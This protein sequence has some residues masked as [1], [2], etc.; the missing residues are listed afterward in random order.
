MLKHC[1]GQW[2]HPRA[3][4]ALSVLYG[5]SPGAGDLIP[6]PLQAGGG[7]VSVRC[8]QESQLLFFG[9]SCNFPFLLGEISGGTFLPSPSL[10]FFFPFAP[11]ANF[12]P[13]FSQFEQISGSPRTLFRT[14]S[15]RLPDELFP[16]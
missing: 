15:V 11:A 16:P 14:C 12:T 13:N 8:R 2:C 1:R 4:V 3:A 6:D 10:F 9:I 5:D 7:C